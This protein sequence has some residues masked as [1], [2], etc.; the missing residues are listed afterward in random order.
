MSGN[1]L[2]PNNNATK[3]EDIADLWYSTIGTHLGQNKVNLTTNEEFEKA[4]L[5]GP[6]EYINEVLN[7]QIPVVYEE[8][9]ILKQNQNLHVVSYANTHNYDISNPQIGVEGKTNHE[10]F[11]QDLLDKNPNDKT[12]VFFSGN[13]IGSEWKISDL[14]NASIDDKGK[15]L[16]WGI[17]PRLQRLVNDI[18]FAARNGADQIFLMNGREEHAAKQKLG[19]DLFD[20]LEKE[21]LADLICEKVAEVLNET[22]NQ[23]SETQGRKVEIAYVKGVKKVFNINREN[24]DGTTSYYTVSMHTNLKTVST[25]FEGNKKAAEKQHAGL[26]QADAIFIQGENVYGT[27]DDENI[28]FLTG[29]SR[30]MKSSKG[31][32]P[33]YSPKGRNSFT[34]LLG[35]NSHDLEI[36]WSMNIIGKYHDVERKLAEVREEEKYLVDLCAKTAIEKYK[37]FAK[38]QAKGYQYYKE[39]REDF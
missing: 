11:K 16:F 3:R 28:V 5:A 1:G 7:K 29:Q 24:E 9:I 13:L 27:V 36:A 17:K 25:L 34:L 21:K 33:G 12:V 10:A 2:N 35:K 39:Q 37:E 18:K 20:E 30:Y 8:P 19:S 4:T 6:T 32:L 31:N 26:A 22:I 14:N 38:N 15:I 23:D